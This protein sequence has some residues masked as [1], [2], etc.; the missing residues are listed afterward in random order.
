MGPTGLPGVPGVKVSSQ[1]VSA[2]PA[3]ACM[4]RF[5]F[6][7]LTCQSLL[8][9]RVIKESRVL[10]CRYNISTSII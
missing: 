2:Q 8:I 1:N 4:L 5:F 6:V 3:P 7:C 10:V 9:H